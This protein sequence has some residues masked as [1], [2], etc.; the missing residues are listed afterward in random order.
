M[1][2]LDVGPFPVCVS[3]IHETSFLL[4]GCIISGLNLT[5]E[6]ASATFS[7]RRFSCLFCRLAL[8]FAAF[9]ASRSALLYDVQYVK[10]G[11][12]VYKVIICDKYIQW[13]NKGFSLYS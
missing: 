3:P 8:S 13:P 9:F 6:S 5:L 12:K 2:E 1:T 11:T 7:A 10:F 4:C